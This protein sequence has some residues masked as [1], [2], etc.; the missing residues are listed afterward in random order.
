MPN[1]LWKVKEHYSFGYVT[2]SHIEPK[3]FCVWNEIGENFYPLRVG[4]GAARRIVLKAIE[5]TG[6]KWKAGYF[7][8][9]PDW[10]LVEAG[11]SG[12]LMD[13]ADVLKAFER[14]H[15]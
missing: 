11:T 4:T 8:H 2:M 10:R 12:G 15:E 9:V 1:V 6:F 14:H 3:V 13:G 5:D 7:D